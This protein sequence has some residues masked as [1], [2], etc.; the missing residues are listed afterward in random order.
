MIRQLGKS[1]VQRQG[2]GYLLLQPVCWGTTEEALWPG[3]HMG[4]KAMMP[5]LMPKPHA[6]GSTGGYSFPLCL[7]PL[8][9]FQ[10]IKGNLYNIFYK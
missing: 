4:S 8:I 3:R 5:I 6:P 10:N 1:W 9:S 2:Q 7:N